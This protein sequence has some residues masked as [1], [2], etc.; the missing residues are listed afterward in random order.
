MCPSDDTSVNLCV[1]WSQILKQALITLLAGKDRLLYLS[2]QSPD[3]LSCIYIK[4]FYSLWLFCCCFSNC[5]VIIHINSFH[6]VSYF[7]LI[8]VLHHIP[9]LDLRKLRLS[10]VKSFAQNHKGSKWQT[11]ASA[12]SNSQCKDHVLRN[13]SL[14]TLFSYFF[15]LPYEHRLSEAHS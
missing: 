14:L 6:I 7:I 8:T 13:C 5:V 15:L 9:I 1:I 2:T 10:D 4:C 3:W 11:Q 12:P